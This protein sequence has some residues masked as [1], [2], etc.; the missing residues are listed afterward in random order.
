MLIDMKAYKKKYRLKNI[1]E[2]IRNA[3][4]AQAGWVNERGT[5]YSI[6]S[7]SGKCGTNGIDF[8]RWET[9]TLKSGATRQVYSQTYMMPVN[10]AKEIVLD[11]EAGLLI[12]DDI[13][14]INVK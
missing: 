12:F 2:T 13:V 6:T 5:S 9:K 10:K 1:S 3:L 14:A 11:T 4:I 7:P 8:W